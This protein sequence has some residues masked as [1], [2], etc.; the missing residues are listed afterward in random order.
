MTCSWSFWS[1]IFYLHR[2]GSVNSRRSHRA[3]T[4]YIF[5]SSRI[6]H[7]GA[8]VVFGAKYIGVLIRLSHNRR[9]QFWWLISNRAHA[10]VHECWIFRL[11]VAT[12]LDT[13]SKSVSIP[14]RRNIWNSTQVMARQ[15]SRAIVISEA[16]FDF[17]LS[18][19][20]LKDILYFSSFI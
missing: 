16:Q 7:G 14:N 12:K 3:S 13:T 20:H 19:F 18:S 9:T 1:L 11:L 8:V 17:H 2:T 10:T 6:L 4:S 15:I 5:I